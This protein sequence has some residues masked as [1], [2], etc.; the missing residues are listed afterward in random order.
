M[1]R[2]EHVVRFKLSDRRGRVK[3]DN[4]FNNFVFTKGLE[5]FGDFFLNN[6]GPTT[7]WLGLLGGSGPVRIQDVGANDWG[8]TTVEFDQAPTI[9]RQP[10]TPT[11]SSWN[12]GDDEFGFEVTGSAQWTAT[13]FTEDGT[14]PDVGDQLIASI[15]E[16]VVMFANNEPVEITGTENNRVFPSSNPLFAAVGATRFEC[17]YN[18]TN[19]GLDTVVEV[20]DTIDVTYTIRF[21]VVDQDF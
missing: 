15:Y 19:P 4:T 12:D 18:L 17:D 16:G 6:A 13:G 2:S 1:I 11:K 8:E 7:L 9:N 21:Q 10:W 20:G 3:H 5:L 14:V